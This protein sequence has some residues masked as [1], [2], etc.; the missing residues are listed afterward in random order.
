MAVKKEKFVVEEAFEQLDNI[1]KQMEDSKTGLEESF[2]LYKQGCDI[3]KKCN[4]S[5]EKVEKELIQ[6]E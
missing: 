1:L 3:L 6:I 4:E 5:I 2:E